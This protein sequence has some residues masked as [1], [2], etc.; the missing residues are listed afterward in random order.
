MTSWKI[1]NCGEELKSE[2][3]SRSQIEKQT[4]A[5]PGKKPCLQTTDL[6]IS[7]KLPSKK[8]SCQP[9]FSLSQGCQR[10][11]HGRG[12]TDSERKTTPAPRSLQTVASRAAR[13]IRQAVAKP[14]VTDFKVRLLESKALLRFFVNRPEERCCSRRLTC[15]AGTELGNRKFRCRFPEAWQCGPGWKALSQPPG[16]LL[17]PLPLH[18]PGRRGR[19]ACHFLHEAAALIEN[20]GGLAYLFSWNAAGYI[21]TAFSQQCGDSISNCSNKKSQSPSQQQAQ[22]TGS[23]CVSP[24]YSAVCRSGRLL[25]QETAGPSLRWVQTPSA[26][27]GDRATGSS[28]WQTP[29]KKDLPPRNSSS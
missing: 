2:T 11:A 18:G 8:G 29:V 3:E 24:A 6:S 14:L 13:G 22:E 12:L 23:D 5:G 27:R 21:F 25:F 7:D 9:D 28:S 19:I 1:P 4:P 17:S 10:L 26:G 15:H 16:P 20:L